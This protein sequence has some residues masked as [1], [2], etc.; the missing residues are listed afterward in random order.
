MKQIV[1]FLIHLYRWLISPFTPPSCRFNPTCSRYAI[2]CI[3]I[4]GLGRGL[5]LAMK[6]LFK[7]HPYENLSKKI[8]S[9]WNYKARQK[10]KVANAPSAP[11]RSH[12]H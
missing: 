11:H 1:I 6:R 5:W 8:A 10:P 4:H 2:N 9:A 12:Q 7:C 3:E